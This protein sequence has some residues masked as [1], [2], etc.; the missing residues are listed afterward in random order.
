MSSIMNGSDYPLGV[1]I[2]GG[3]GGFD[4]LNLDLPPNGRQQ[5]DV[6]DDGPDLTIVGPFRPPPLAP[7]VEQPYRCP[8]CGGRGFVPV[9]FYATLTY[10]TSVTTDPCRSCA[11]DGVLWRRSHAPVGGSGL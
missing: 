4:G 9:G 11:G 10:T 5:I 8:I 2:R 6:G 7:L 1:V 3:R